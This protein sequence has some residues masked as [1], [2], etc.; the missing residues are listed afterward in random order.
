[1]FY[2]L[3]WDL[4]PSQHIVVIYKYRHNRFNVYLFNSYVK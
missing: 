4:R 2:K 3:G 1:L